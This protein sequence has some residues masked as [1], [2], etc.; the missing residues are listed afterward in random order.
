MGYP[1]K[2]G[3]ASND[4]L[5]YGRIPKLFREARCFKQEKASISERPR[6]TG[7]PNH[8]VTFVLSV[9]NLEHVLFIGLQK[10]IHTITLGGTRIL[11][12]WTPW[13][14]NISALVGRASRRR[15]CISTQQDSK[16]GWREAEANTEN[17]RKGLMYA[18][19]LGYLISE[20]PDDD[21]RNAEEGLVS[22]SRNC[23]FFC[24]VIF[25][26]FVD[27]SDSGGEI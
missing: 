25:C 22:A 19:C 20:A 7:I 12:N 18:R 13:S 10:R 24:I 5:R 26:H 9:I 6:H 16:V 21:S 27:L 8:V 4:I 23:I 17:D 1:R 15:K 14:T 11:V 3:R 2:W